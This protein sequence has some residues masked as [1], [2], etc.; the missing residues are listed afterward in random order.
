MYGSLQTK[1]LHGD[2]RHKIIKAPELSEGLLFDW[3]DWVLTF[4]TPSVKY[5]VLLNVSPE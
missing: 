3:A 2:S 1:V 4:N 5:H